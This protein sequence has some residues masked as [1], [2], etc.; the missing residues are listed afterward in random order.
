MPTGLLGEGKL[1]QPPE[2]FYLA[3]TNPEAI[4]PYAFSEKGA[5]F[6]LGIVVVLLTDNLPMYIIAQG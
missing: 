2:F 3:K 5:L 1:I 4:N 6:L